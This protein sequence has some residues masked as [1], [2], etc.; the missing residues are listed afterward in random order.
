VVDAFFQ[1]VIK[2]FSKSYFWGDRLLTLDKSKG[3]LNDPVFAKANS[4]RLLETY[5]QFSPPNNIE[6]RLNTLVWA[7]RQ[8]LRLEGDFV[9]CGVFRGDMSWVVAEC[10]NFSQ[11]K[12]TFYLYDSFS[13]FPPK[14]QTAE[15]YPFNPDFLAFAQKAYSADEDL[16]AKVTKRFSVYPNVQV[17][18]GYVPDSF[19][20]ALPEKIAY[21]HLDLN[22]PAAEIAALDVLFDRIVPGGTIVFDDYGWADFCKQKEQEDAWFRARGLTVLELPTGQGMVIKV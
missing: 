2:P 17:I 18:P 19:Q 21:L 7:A 16:A 3:F 5:D 8:G 9:E 10:L 4:E 20:K 13:G 15:D 22:S 14:L 6:W 11:V 12:K 1:K